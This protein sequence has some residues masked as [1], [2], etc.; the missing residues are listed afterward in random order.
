M[1]AWCIS[2]EHYFIVLEDQI[3]F[4]IENDTDLKIQWVLIEISWKKLEFLEVRNEVAGETT[5]EF[6]KWFVVEDWKRHLQRNEHE[7]RWDY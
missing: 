4:W 1:I 3:K 6:D 2:H 5:T 7:H